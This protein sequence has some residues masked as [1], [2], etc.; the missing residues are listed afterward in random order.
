VVKTIT[1][2]G[3]CRF[4]TRLVSL[5]N[6]LSNQRIGMEKTDDDLWSLRSD[7]VLRATFDERDYTIQG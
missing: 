4:G 1:T 5:A 6:A 3:T 2:G 7:T